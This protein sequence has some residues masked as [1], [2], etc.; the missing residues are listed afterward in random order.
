MQACCQHIPELPVA[1]TEK[2]QASHVYGGVTEMA[3]E[4]VKQE[5]MGFTP[6]QLEKLRE[7]IMSFRD[8][9]VSFWL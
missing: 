2:L 6:P 1:K 9:K 5:P 8:L 7:Q 4:D 3:I